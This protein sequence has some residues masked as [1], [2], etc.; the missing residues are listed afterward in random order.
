MEAAV[1]MARALSAHAEAAYQVM[2]ASPE[3]KNA[4][5]L[6][7][8][9]RDRTRDSG[10]NQFSGNDIY[11]LARKKTALR[12]KEALTAALSVLKARGYVRETTIPTGGRPKTVFTL[13]PLAV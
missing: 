3:E 13:N 8:R 2:G 12:D 11:A 9:L 10:R 6:W 1:K 4:Q 7:Q 5:Y